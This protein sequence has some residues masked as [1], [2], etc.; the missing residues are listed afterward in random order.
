MSQQIMQSSTSVMYPM[1]IKTSYGSQG[2]GSVG[3]DNSMGK[4]TSVSNF[5][6]GNGKCAQLSGGVSGDA[7]SLGT[8]NSSISQIDSKIARNFK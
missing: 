2:V 1:L 8:V 5:G 4:N 6:G 7:S 3:G